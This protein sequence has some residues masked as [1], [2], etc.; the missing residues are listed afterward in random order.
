M[1]MPTDGRFLQLTVNFDRENTH[2]NNP[3][4]TGPIIVIASGLIVSAV[5]W[6]FGGIDE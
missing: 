2:M 6:L 3:E 4:L 1:P 5:A